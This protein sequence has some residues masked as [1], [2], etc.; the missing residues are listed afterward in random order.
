MK[1]KEV[2]IEYTEEDVAKMRAEGIDE[3]AIPAVGKH[4]FHRVDR[5]KIVPR[6]ESKARINIF[7]DLDIID[8]FRNRA[9][10]PNAAPYQTQMNAE[11]RKVME[12]DLANEEPHPLAAY[13]ELLENDEFLKKLS[14]KLKERELQPA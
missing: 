7:I 5:R 10:Q 2:I 9:E 13:D 14:Q 3:D 4:V 11:L 8:H 1:N 6:K 12:R